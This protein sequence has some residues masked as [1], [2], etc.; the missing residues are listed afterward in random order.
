MWKVPTSG[1]VAVTSALRQTAGTHRLVQVEHVVAGRRDEPGRPPHGGRSQRDALDRAVRPDADGPAQGHER[2]RVREVVARHEDVGAQALGTEVVRQAGH[3]R[4][5]PSRLRHRVGADESDAH[6][7]SLPSAA[8]GPTPGVGSKPS[9]VRRGG[10][11]R[12]HRMAEAR[13]TGA[14]RPRLRAGPMRRRRRTS[15][16]RRLPPAGHPHRDP[17]ARPRRRR[18]R[19]PRER[20]RPSPRGL[21]G[22]ER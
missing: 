13:M 17:R 18:A 1:E 11:G 8:P 15:T 21:R 12:A 7:A 20:R 16:L 3:V 10:A 14:E 6:G 4:L 22:D 9:R 19:A 5:D 2:R